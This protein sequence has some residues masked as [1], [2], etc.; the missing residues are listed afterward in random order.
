MKSGLR[1]LAR[2]ERPICERGTGILPGQALG[3]VHGLEFVHSPHGEDGLATCAAWPGWPCYVAPA[4][5]ARTGDGQPCAPTSEFRK[6]IKNATN[7]AVMSLKTKES[8]V[9]AQN[10]SR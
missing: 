8:Q 3:E 4:F 1:L 5:T 2:P 10:E 6:K 7:K 9:C